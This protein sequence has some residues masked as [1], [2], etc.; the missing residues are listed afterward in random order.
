M[1]TGRP[2]SI[3]P[4]TS[5]PRNSGHAPAVV[6]TTRKLRSIMRH[7]AVV[8]LALKAGL[9]EPPFGASF[10]VQPTI[11]ELGASDWIRAGA[12]ASVA[13][14][15]MICKEFSAVSLAVQCLGSFARAPLAHAWPPQAGF[16]L[17]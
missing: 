1:A 13:T 17:D 6:R 12:S 8:R 5:I 7:K 10:R 11:L 4:S 2:L 3:S 15:V 16:P 9:P 14:S